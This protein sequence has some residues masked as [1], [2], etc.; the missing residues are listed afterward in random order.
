MTTPRI[1]ARSN[2]NMDVVTSQAV[3]NIFGYFRKYYNF[4]KV[5]NPTYIN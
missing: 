1:S 5:Y 4:R 2:E 3:A